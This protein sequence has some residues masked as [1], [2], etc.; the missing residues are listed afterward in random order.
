MYIPKGNKFCKRDLKILEMDLLT[1]EY[2]CG[3]NS[4]NESSD[5]NSCIRCIYIYIIGH[6]Y[7]KIKFI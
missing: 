1:V 3:I 5:L 6:S 4:N 7:E 2:V